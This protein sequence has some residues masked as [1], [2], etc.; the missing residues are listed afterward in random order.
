MAYLLG[1]SI[2]PVVLFGDASFLKKNRDGLRKYAQEGGWVLTCSNRAGKPIPPWLK[3]L[4][5][6][7]KGLGTDR[8][9]WNGNTGAAAINVALLFG[10]NP[11]YLLGYDMK[12]GPDGK[13]NYHNAYSQTPNPQVYTRFKR[14][15]VDLLKD[16]RAEW[17]GQKIINLEDGT[18]DL[19]G[20]PKASLR[21]H[22]KMRS[23]ENG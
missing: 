13:G 11:I 3:I 6:T 9:G 14:R 17:R 10:A 12:I 1:P 2:C 15:F 16:W 18:S 22:L 5:R 7:V 19:Q 20:F 8:I 21:E 4:K 23:E